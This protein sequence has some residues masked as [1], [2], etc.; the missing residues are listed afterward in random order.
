MRVTVILAAGAGS[1][2]IS[3][4][5]SRLP[6]S[7][8]EKTFVVCNSET[9]AP[10]DQRVRYVD[11]IDKVE[12]DSSD[13]VLVTDTSP[14]PKDFCK[15]ECPSDEDTALCMSGIRI[16]G[17][18]V[19][20]GGNMLSIEKI[21]NTGEYVE[22][23]VGSSSPV[24]AFTSFP[25]AM[26]GS[27]FRKAAE[28]NPGEWTPMSLSETLAKCGFKMMCVGTRNDDGMQ[29]T[30]FER[31]FIKTNNK[32]FL[33]IAE[34]NEK[35]Y[36]EKKRLMRASKE[37]D[38]RYLR[39]AWAP[40]T[41]ED[42]SEPYEKPDDAQG[43]TVENQ[44]AHDAIRN[45]LA[46]MITTHNRTATACT[47]LL[48]LLKNLVHD[49]IRWVISDDRSEPGHV[50]TIL[51]FM[52]NHRF[53]MSKVTVRRT[54]EFR[55]GL[56]AAINNGLDEGF[57]LSDVVLRTE[58]D[59]YLD[60]KLDMYRYIKILE[61]REVCGIRMAAWGGSVK[62]S[63]WDGML[64]AYN[65][66]ED[67]KELVFNNQVMLV[68]RRSR[69]VV[70]RYPENIGGAPSEEAVSARYNRKT[71]GGNVPPFVLIDGATK[72]FRLN[73]GPFFSHIGVESTE[74]HNYKMAPRRLL[75]RVVDTRKEL[76]GMK[77]RPT[78]RICY[79]GDD[80][81]MDK[82]ATSVASIANTGNRCLYD[83]HVLTVG[84]VS[85]RSKRLFDGLPANMKIWIE[86]VPNEIVKDCIS[87]DPSIGAEKR[88]GFIDRF[89]NGKYG[90]TS[91]S[92]RWHLHRIFD[93]PK[94][95]YVDGDIIFKKPPID[96]FFTDVSDVLA[97]GVKDAW[98]VWRQDRRNSSYINSGVMLFNLEKCR[99]ERFHEKC[100]ERAP[101]K[102]Y[103]FPYDQDVINEA[104]GNDRAILPLAFN[105]P[106]DV[107]IESCG[108]N[109]GF[110][111]EINSMYGTRYKSLHEM[112]STCVCMHFCG[113]K[114]WL[115]DCHMSTVW[116]Y[117]A[118]MVAK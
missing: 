28:K 61:S 34:R 58:D 25:V 94:I 106:V 13:V 82:I 97:G 68:H 74:L 104:L 76:S 90:M 107:I 21:S 24:D 41:G 64:I 85:S 115:G 11:S 101:S 38:E 2:A 75:E 110:I 32:Y 80:R 69:D 79:I 54:D 42:R 70:G 22:S 8:T 7:T 99:S 44:D 45:V 1:A 40:E 117:Y 65:L 51:S 93:F 96:L 66:W 87:V 91:Q 98:N 50:E 9:P 100:N 27:C 20:I 102:K 116:N 112:L 15:I 59:W 63:K 55:Y 81:Y 16:S 89:I 62:E 18:G 113:R 56:G 5:V 71:K 73:N 30:A 37:R 53:D 108:S 14:V 4:S 48:S 57:R 46:V 88:N 67:S 95:L 78:V 26:P 29:S 31:A 111:D 12:C 35:V 83:V 52:E 72:P 23:D 10:T 114:P 86:A 36:L 33:E 3:E 17:D 92:S 19:R 118:D 60:R 43:H 6:K 84:P 49:D 103:L 109:E 77:K 39:D 105:F 47:C